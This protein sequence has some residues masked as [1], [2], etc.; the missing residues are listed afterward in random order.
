MALTPK[1]QRFVEEY[2]IDLNATQ[3]AIRAG[4]SPK[5]GTVRGAE[6]LANRN[7]SAAIE[8]AKAARSERTATDADYVLKG[9]RAEAEYK[10]KGASHSA[11]VQAYIALGRHLG[12]FK[13]KLEVTGKDGGPVRYADATD[14][15]LDAE[16]TR[17]QSV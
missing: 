16:I 5:G 11:R 7:V 4:Y 9:L 13:D 1:Q 15:D 8:A 10:G 2:L 12:M 3:A 17:L 14:A 6:L